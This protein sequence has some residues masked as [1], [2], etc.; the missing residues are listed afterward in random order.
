[1]II[2]FVRSG[3]LLLVATY[4][5]AGSAQA[6][7]QLIKFYPVGTPKYCKGC[8]HAGTSF[9]NL[10]IQIENI[11][12]GDL[13]LYGTKLG[14]EFYALNMFQRRNPN[15]C[16]WEYGYGESVRR[17]SWAEMKDYE[18]VAR[19]L[20]AGEIL[21][22]DG[23]FD[24]SDVKAPTRYTAFIG[25][26]SDSIPTEVFSTPFVPVF[27]ETTDAASFR[28][29]DKVCSPQCKIGI[30]ESPQIMG[31]RLGM[32]LKDFRALYPHVKVHRLHEKLA[33][34]KVAYIWAWSWDAYSV[35]VTFIN[36]KVARIEP[37]FRSLEKSRDRPD[38]WERISSAIGLPYFW[39][40]FQLEW[41]C[42]D[43]V[44]EVTPNESP[45]IT[46]QTPEYMKLRDRIN[47][48]FIKNMKVN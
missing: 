33:N 10:T 17:V 28:L 41:K 20:K 46:I 45:T 30:S 5:L 19:V 36:D 29:V 43:F 24:E 31:V 34:Y 22:A 39:E 4:L 35:N 9:W 21:E 14:D 15:V 26:P 38:F 27:G 18:K 2:K 6:Q 32:S 47:N 42:P 1:M 40:P 12:G 48:E 13:I 44:V 16:E 37:K 25:K 23:G 3:I 11:S 8:G 7:D